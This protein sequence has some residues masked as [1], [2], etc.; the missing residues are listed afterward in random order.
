M[1]AHDQSRE[2]FETELLNA[3]VEGLN[4]VSLDTVSEDEHG[5]AL[6]NVAPRPPRLCDAMPS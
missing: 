5:V 1:S 2:D 6:H 4:G 3:A